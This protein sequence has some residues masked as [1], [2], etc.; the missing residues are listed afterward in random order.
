LTVGSIVTSVFWILVSVDFSY[1]AANFGSFNKTYGSLGAVVGFMMWMWISTLVIL[2]GAEID[3]V[4]EH[5]D[6]GSAK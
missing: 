5:A 1:Y 6:R 3:S 2:G 4:L